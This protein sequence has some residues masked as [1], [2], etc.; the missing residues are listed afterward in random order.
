MVHT[1]VE[2]IDFLLFV[3]GIDGV[4]E[5]ELAPERQA[6]VEHTVGVVWVEA[7]VLGVVRVAHVAVVVVFRGEYRVPTAKEVSLV[8]VVW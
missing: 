2:S 6:R 3:A 7:I 4:R 5:S 1:R 8:L